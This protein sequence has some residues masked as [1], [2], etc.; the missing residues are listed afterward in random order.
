MLAVCFCW[1]GVTLYFLT[2][3]HAVRLDRRDD[4]GH[5]AHVQNCCNWLVEAARLT[6]LRNLSRDGHGRAVAVPAHANI[7]GRYT[8]CF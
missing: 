6:A 1:I 2:I 7:F 4:G 5:S 3:L 8:E